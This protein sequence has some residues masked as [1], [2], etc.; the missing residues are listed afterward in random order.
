MIL[1]SLLTP[2]VATETEKEIGDGFYAVVSLEEMP[3]T[4]TCSPDGTI[5]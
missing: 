2:A 1:A 4:F 5:S 3:L